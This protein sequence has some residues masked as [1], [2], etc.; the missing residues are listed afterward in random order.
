MS[1]E[2]VES[3][4]LQIKQIRSMLNRVKS[5]QVSQKGVLDA[6]KDMVKYYFDQLR[7][8]LA[9]ESAETIDSLMHALLESAN[10]YTSKTVYGRHLRSLA[11]ELIS[12]EKVLLQPPLVKDVGFNQIDIDILQTLRDVSL[13][14]ALSYEQGLLDLRAESRLSW[15]G[16][17]TD[18]R[19]ALRETLDVLAPDKDVAGA[20]GFRLEQDARGPT[21]KQKVSYL[22]RTRG[23]SKSRVEAPQRVVESV[24]E[25]VG[26]FVRSVY[27]RSSIATHTPTNKEEVSRVL[28]YVRVALA[29]LLEIR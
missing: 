14:A 22:L 11:V 21:M 12:L 24:E 5:V 28:G 27:T 6:V 19:E 13:S 26:S 16:P 9:V 2:N 29:E 8:R 17:A 18:L 20:D 10:K 7:P 4:R 1:R 15:R 23:V 3:I 25:I